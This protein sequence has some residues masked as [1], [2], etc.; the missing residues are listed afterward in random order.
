MEKI[1]TQEQM[2]VF[3]NMAESMMKAID[4]EMIRRIQQELLEKYD[5]PEIKRKSEELIN[6]IKQ[7]QNDNN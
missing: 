2:N 6:L 3:D 4:Q 7:T 1:T 5:D